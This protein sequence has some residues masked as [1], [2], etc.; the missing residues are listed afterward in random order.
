MSDSFFRV[1]R[2]DNGGTTGAYVWGSRAQ[3][4]VERGEKVHEWFKLGLC[5]DF[6]ERRARESDLIKKYKSQT[7]LPPVKSEECENLVVNYLSGVKGAV[8]AFFTA[9]PD[10]NVARCPRDYIITVPALWD[11]AEQEKTRRCAERAGMGE[12]TQLQIISE[13]EAACIYAIQT[14]LS[15]NVH[16]TY[17]ICDAGGG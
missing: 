11:H 7:A 17:V 6:E 5:N 8:D 12:G 9:N 4:F 16:D 14:M 1:L 10:E 15:P 2:Y 3:Q 13:P